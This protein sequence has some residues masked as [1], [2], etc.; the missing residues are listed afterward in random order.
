MKLTRAFAAVA[1]ATG[2]IAG[3]SA[4][5]SNAAT[6]T[7]CTDRAEGGARVAYGLTSDQRVFVS[8]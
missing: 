8:K 3:T 2:A 4:I 5:P 7:K 1:I 6:P